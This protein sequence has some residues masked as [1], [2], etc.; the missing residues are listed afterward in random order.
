[1]DEQLAILKKGLDDE[2]VAYDVAM[3][4]RKSQYET[5]VIDAKASYEEK[6]A[7]LQKELDAEV[8]IRERYAEDFKRIGDR[9]AL[10]DITLL[11]NKYNDEKAEMELEHQERLAEIRESAFEEG[12]GFGD[13]F[14]AGL[15]STLLQTQEK[16]A[17]LRGDI[18][19]A[20]SYAEQFYDYEKGVCYNPSS[21]FGQSFTGTKW[22]QGGLATQPGIVGES[23][24]EVVLPL[25]FPK[26][27]D[28][29]MQSFG[30]GGNRGGGNV[31]QNFYVTVN[32]PQDVD[33]LM[34][35]AGFAMKNQGGL[36]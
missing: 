8:V 2:G 7:E 21:P 6:R 9:M 1:M 3:A 22:A 10:D 18:S 26:R 27:M 4:K 31:T 5:D 34:E 19:S 36:T 32:N 28:Q 14:G 24:P 13:S 11:V 29:I 15:D 17:Q 30:L 16:L 25:N 35:R 20:Q 33:V 12:K 23:G